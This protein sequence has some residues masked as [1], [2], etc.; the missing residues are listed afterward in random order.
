MRRQGHRVL[1]IVVERGPVGGVAAMD[2][3]MQAGM[4]QKSAEGR[5][6]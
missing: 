5:D 6:A 1:G 4:G 3:R 2:G